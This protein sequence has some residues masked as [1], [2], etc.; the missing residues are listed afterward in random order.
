MT[1]TELLGR[2]PCKRRSGSYRAYF[3]T[4]EEAEAFAANS[5]RRDTDQQY[6]P[7]SRLRQAPLK[8][9]PHSNDFRIEIWHG[10][11]PVPR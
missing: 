7:G 9:R 11:R 8:S 5:L 10:C 6:Q 2:E 4:K 3:A 1:L